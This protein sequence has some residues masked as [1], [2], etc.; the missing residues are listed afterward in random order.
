MGGKG[1]GG[2]GR[3]Q[4]RKAKEPTTTVGFRVS[5]EALTVVKKKYGRT[6]N[7]KVNDTIKE[8]AKE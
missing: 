6:L 3:G 2:A 8:W 5:T 4:G 7:A 1:S